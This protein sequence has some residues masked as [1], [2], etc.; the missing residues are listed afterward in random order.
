MP[1]SDL[2]GLTDGEEKWYGTDPTQADSDLD[3]LSDKDG[4]A[5][6]SRSCFTMGTPMRPT[7][8]W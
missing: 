2:D 3:G 8:G 1:D 6:R 7:T 5:V 4:C